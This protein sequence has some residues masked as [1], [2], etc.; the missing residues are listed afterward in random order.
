MS[1]TTRNGDGG[2]TRLYSGEEV[3]KDAPEVD[4][5]GELDELGTLLG[6][7]R[8]HVM[9][10]ETGQA[11]L[12]LQRALF[13]VAA[14]TATR[15]GHR[16]MLTVR[17]DEAMVDELDRA[18]A[19]LE[20]RITMPGG[21]V[22]PG[23]NP[24][25]AHLDHARAVSRRCERKVIGLARSGAVDNPALLAWVNRVSDYLWL[26]ARLEEGDTTIPKD[27]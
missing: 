26:L 19:D 18:C 27:G 4:A 25:G 8:M 9:R 3:A 6:I 20:A 2:K 21:F 12:D 22:I 17:V 15:P 7:A 24:A 11:L 16:D 14:E 13:L 1:I 5:C 10:K 23:G